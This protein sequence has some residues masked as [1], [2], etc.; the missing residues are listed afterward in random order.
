[1]ADKPA[2]TDKTVQTT[3]GEKA[4]PSAFSD[5][6]LNGPTTQTEKTP[7]TNAPKESGDLSVTPIQTLLPRNEAPTAPGTPSDT[8]VPHKDAAKDSSD[9]S[10]EGR[11]DI[12]QGQENILNAAKDAVGK[13]LWRGTK[14]EGV[15]NEGKLGAAASVSEVLKQS[16]VTDADSASISTLEQK[17]KDSGFVMKGLTD[18]QPGDVV[19][20]QPNESNPSKRIGIVGPPNSEGKPTIYQMDTRGTWR[21][22][23][24]RVQNNSNTKVYTPGCGE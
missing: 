11:S 4:D 19:V 6:R 20:Y 10:A 18:A 9:K 24:M 5:Y 12:N 13:E 22:H 7:P 1:M 15:V 16:G 21:H 17:L 3:S 8:N 14:H 2:V 23:E